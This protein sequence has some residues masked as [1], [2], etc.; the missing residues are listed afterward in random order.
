[1]QITCPGAVELPRAIQFN[2]VSEFLPSFS[3]TSQL[4]TAN[5]NFRLVVV[6]RRRRTFGWLSSKRLPP[7]DAPAMYRERNT[8][9]LNWLVYFVL[10][11]NDVCSEIT[12]FVSLCQAMDFP[13]QTIRCCRETSDQMAYNLRGAVMA[14]E[15]SR[16]ELLSCGN[17]KASS[18]QG[19]AATRDC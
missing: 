11:V 10:D 4:R 14:L 2:F 6:S 1:M 7:K 5:A 19:S 9:S 3:L 16:V 18:R 17:F 12:L 15:S 13:Y 8:A